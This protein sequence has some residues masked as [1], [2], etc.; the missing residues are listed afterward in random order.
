LRA[1]EECRGKQPDEIAELL[2]EA[3]ARCKAG[4]ARAGSA[5]LVLALPRARNRIVANVL[6]DI[7]DAQGLPPSPH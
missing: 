4:N 6:S 2:V 7:L 3:N 5:V 1:F